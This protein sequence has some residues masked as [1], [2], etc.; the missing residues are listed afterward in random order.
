MTGIMERVA[1]LERR[2]AAVEHD[3]IMRIKVL[4]AKQEMIGKLCEA[5]HLPYHPADS[6]PHA[7]MDGF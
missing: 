2:V 5:R 7:D 3:C 1:D 6:L 4:E